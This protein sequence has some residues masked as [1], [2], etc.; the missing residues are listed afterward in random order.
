LRSGESVSGG[1]AEGESED[2][3]LLQRW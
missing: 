2:I 3:G 1:G